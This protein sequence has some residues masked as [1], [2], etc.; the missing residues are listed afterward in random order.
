MNKESMLGFI[1]SLGGKDEMNEFVDSIASINKSISKLFKGEEDDF[2]KK[3]EGYKEEKKDKKKR[4]D[5]KRTK[6]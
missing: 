4:R 2:K 3:Q 1:A 6:R 5:K